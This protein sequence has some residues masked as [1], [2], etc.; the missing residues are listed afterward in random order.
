MVLEGALTDRSERI[1]INNEFW[2]VQSGGI[3]ALPK[4]LAKRIENIQVNM[5]A[6]KYDCSE[7]CPPH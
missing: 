4:A 5:R 7:S 6:T 3:E 1:G 2:T